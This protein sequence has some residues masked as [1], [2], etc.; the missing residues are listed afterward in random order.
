MIDPY[1]LI[2]GYFYQFVGHHDHTYIV[3]LISFD[4]EYYYFK[5]YNYIASTYITNT[6]QSISDII[7]SVHVLNFREEETLC[8]TV[9][10]KKIL[11]KLK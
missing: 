2:V 1:N 11:E 8:R 6:R 10:L 7:K 5:P 3:E 4:G 9:K